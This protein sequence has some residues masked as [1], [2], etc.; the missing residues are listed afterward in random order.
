MS[1]SLV[2]AKN[3]IKTKTLITVRR[4]VYRSYVQNWKS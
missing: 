1:L 3:S 4:Y 2:L